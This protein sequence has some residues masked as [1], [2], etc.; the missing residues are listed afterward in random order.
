[1]THAKQIG[2]FGLGVT[3]N[4]LAHRLIGAARVGRS[5]QSWQ[6]RFA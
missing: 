4:A 6:R 1:M 3:G 2:I 5:G